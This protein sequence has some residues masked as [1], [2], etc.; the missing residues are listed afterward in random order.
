MGTVGRRTRLTPE[1]QEKI[2]SALRT[3]NYIRTAAG[4]ANVGESSVYAWLDRGRNAITAGA[5]NEVWIVDP[6]DPDGD[7]ILSDDGIPDRE[8]RYVDFVEAMDKA[9]IEAE[10]RMATQWSMAAAKDWRAA[11][12]F[13]ARRYPERW[14]DH[15]GGFGSGGLGDGF[16][17]LEIESSSVPTAEGAI[18][19]DNERTAAILAVLAEVAHIPA[20]ALEAATESADDA[21]SH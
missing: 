3:G 12:E 19:D 5:A 8:R 17:S 20:G 2:C 13:L 16:G 15:G 7:H 11:K 6:E 1:V 4:W 10:I 18:T 14:G 9:E 21:A